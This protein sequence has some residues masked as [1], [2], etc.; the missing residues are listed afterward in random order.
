MG[1]KFNDKSVQFDMKWLP[2]TIKAGRDGMAVVEVDGKTYTP[3]EIIS[4]DFAKNQSRMPKVI[5]AEK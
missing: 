1:R 5:W 3:Q 2:Y 4:H